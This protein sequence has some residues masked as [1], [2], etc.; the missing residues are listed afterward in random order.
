MVI[1][2]MGDSW[3]FD[4]FPNCKILKIWYFSKLN[5]FKNL[6]IFGIFQI[7]IFLS[8]STW[9]SLDFSQLEIV[10]ISQLD[11]FGI[12]QIANLLNIPNWKFC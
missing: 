7:E 3:N 1:D 9:K 6:E 8:F 11:I 12:F 4:S 10:G 2:K 5:N